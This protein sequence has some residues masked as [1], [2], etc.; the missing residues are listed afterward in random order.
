MRIEDGF[1]ASACRNRQTQTARVRLSAI[2]SA[3]D[4]V[5]IER[6]I[7]PHYTKWKRGDGVTGRPPV[8]PVA[9]VVLLLMTLARSWSR[10][11]TVSFLSKHKEWVRFL[12]LEGVPDETIWSKLLERVPQETLDA[13]LRDLVRDLVKKRVLKLL[14]TAADGSF[15]PACHWDKEADWGYVRRKDKRAHPRGR[16]LENEEGKLLGLGYRVHVVVDADAELPMAVHVM[17]ANLPDVTQYATLH[18]IVENTV[19]WNNVGWFTADKGYDAGNV[20]MAFANRTTRVVIPA[21]NTP[22]DLKAGGFH[23]VQARVYKKRT[24][25]ER[26][27]SLLKRFLSFDRWGITGLERVRKWTTLAAIASILIQLAN[28]ALGNRPRSVEQFL[29][30]LA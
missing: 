17:P 1:A 16:F 26:F 24:G 4:L 19:G 2:L 10:K 14:V 22:R 12:D 6:V 7:R 8:N 5:K 11:D 29:R 27:F 9:L 25:V 18:R 28:R 20:R 13:L 15:L 3:I 21:A 30:A 23:G